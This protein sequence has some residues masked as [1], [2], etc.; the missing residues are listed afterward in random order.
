MKLIVG[1]GNHGEKYKNTRHNI[2]FDVVQRL[3]MNDVR[4]T[5]QNFHFDK[6]SSS[7]ILKGEIGDEEVI[8]ARPQTF[9]NNSGLAVKKLSDTSNLAPETLII[10]HD[11]ISL[12]L[13]QVKI[14]KNAGAGNHNGVQSIIDHLKTK[15]FI[16]IRCG[17]GRGDGILSD[18]VLSKFRPDEK[19]MV[20]QMIQK[21]RDACVVIVKEGLEKAMNV[22]N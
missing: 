15:D 16:R 1:L 4:S 22:V 18:V 19:E 3:A 8:I 17:I 6:I 13:G 11:D 7:E 12:E 9:M 2:G 20:D 10:V 21:A 5:N 14:S